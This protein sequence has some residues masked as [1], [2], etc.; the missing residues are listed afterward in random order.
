[1][2]QVVA[3]DGEHAVVAAEPSVLGGQPPFQQVE[4][5]NA[6][7]VR[8]SHELDAQLFSGVPLVKGHVEDLFSRGSPLGMAGRAAAK[9]PLA[10]HGEP[11]G[12]AGLREDG[13][14]VVVRHVADVVA[15][16]LKDLVSSEES[17][18]PGDD[19]VPVYFLDYDVY[20]WRFV[21]THDADS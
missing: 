18:V 4:N 3:V 6:W 17:S 10:Q 7:L 16:D 13:A 20:Q 2:L 19:P 5:E 1:M 12:A 14:R 15:V 11:Q 8:P 9:A 21:T